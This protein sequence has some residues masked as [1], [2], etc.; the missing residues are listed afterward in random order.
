[1]P[2]ENTLILIALVLPFVVFALTIAWADFYSRSIN[3]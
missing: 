1:M 2:Q 3:K